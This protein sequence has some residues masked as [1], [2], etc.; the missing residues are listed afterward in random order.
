MRHSRPTKNA[1]LGIKTRMPDVTVSVVRVMA[2]GFHVYVDGPAAYAPFAVMHD[3]GVKRSAYET[4]TDAT[5]LKRPDWESLAQLDGDI[6]LYMVGSPYDDERDGTLEAETLAN[7]LWQM[8]PAVKAGRA[9]KVD[10][11]TWMAFGGLASANRIL[12]DVERYVV[13]VEP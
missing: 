12:D 7:P 10:I 6:L 8:L 13:A 4:V 1:P 5:I 3:A 11:A 2:G 9:H